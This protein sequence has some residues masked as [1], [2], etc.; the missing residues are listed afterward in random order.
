VLA[1]RL[2]KD[3]RL[4]RAGTLADTNVPR[5]QRLGVRNVSGH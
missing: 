5:E 1:N 4:T 2:S 3:Y